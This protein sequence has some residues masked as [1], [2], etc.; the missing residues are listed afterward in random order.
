MD[1]LSANSV[2]YRLEM[3]PLLSSYH[4]AFSKTFIAFSSYDVI[5][6]SVD[7]RPVQH[8]LLS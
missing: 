1:H 7:T 8:D 5:R 6:D 3:L 2:S 4:L